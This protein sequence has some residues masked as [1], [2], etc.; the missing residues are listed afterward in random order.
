MVKVLQAFGAG[1]LG[2]SPAD[3][4]KEGY[5]SQIGYPPLRIDILNSID[6]VSFTEAYPNKNT[7]RIEDLEINFIGLQDMMRIKKHQAEVRT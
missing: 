2:L 4:L 5:V 1:S 3:F 7:I 6:G